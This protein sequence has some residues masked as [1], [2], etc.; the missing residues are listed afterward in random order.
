MGQFILVRPLGLLGALFLGIAFSSCTTEDKCESSLIGSITE[1]EYKDTLHSG[2]SYS[3]QIKVAGFNGC[4]ELESI[5]AKQTGYSINITGK[6]RNK[7]CTCTM[8]YPVFDG[9]YIFKPETT[10]TYYLKFFNDYNEKYL[11][12]TVVVI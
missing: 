3:Y 10:G 11:I 12:D 4:S 8:I 1:I 7:G 6:I 9:I 5:N 2:S